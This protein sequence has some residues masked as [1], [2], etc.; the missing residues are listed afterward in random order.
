MDY[1][2]LARD[3]V[4]RAVERGVEAEAYINVG[5]NTEVNVDRGEVEKLSQAGAKGLGVRV[6]RDGKMGYAY[7]SD[8]TAGS[9][10]KTIEAAVHPVR[11]R[12]RR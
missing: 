3:I 2:K 7:T 6:I 12:G 9:I 11:C 8:F 4:S 10:E 5:Q 1:L